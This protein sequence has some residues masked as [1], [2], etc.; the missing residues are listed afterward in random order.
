MA[1]NV[2]STLREN[3][4]P[5]QAKIWRLSS[6]LL[7]AKFRFGTSKNRVYLSARIECIY[8]QEYSLFSGRNTAYFSAKIR[9]IMLVFPNILNIFMS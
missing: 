5:P 3:A 8:R 9:Y 6:R 7:A 2:A 4:L 1:A